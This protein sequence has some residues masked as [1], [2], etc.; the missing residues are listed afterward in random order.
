MFF[1]TKKSAKMRLM[2][3]NSGVFEENIYFYIIKLMINYGL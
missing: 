1:N 3:I 2:T